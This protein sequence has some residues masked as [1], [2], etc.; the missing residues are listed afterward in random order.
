M[1]VHHLSARRS[2][3]SVE[4]MISFRGVAKSFGDVPALAKVDLDV[5][6]G[7]FIA[8]VGP[9]GCGK[10][11]LLGMAAGILQPTQG[12]V[13]FRG[14][15]V[16]GPNRRAGFITQQ[17]LLLPWRTVEENVRLPLE[18]R[19]ERKHAK[20]RVAEVLER[21]GLTTF[22]RKYPAQLSG[23]MRKRV[24]IA[25]TLVYNPD[26]YLMDEPFGSLDA[27]LRTVMHTEVLRLW[28]D[29][30]STIVFVTHDLTEAIVLAQRVAV[31]SRRPGVIQ[32]IEDIDMDKSGNRDAV[33]I[34]TDPGFQQSL[35]RLWSLLDKPE[36]H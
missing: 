2:I 12:E 6:G 27:Q 5:A 11:T 10:S 26:V 35:G 24:S 22:A 21:V 20:E 1:P 33:S 25:R 8:V 19:K 9:S 34:Q 23:G 7:E 36:I 14:E 3:V 28:R 15:R 4:P 13:R 17:D 32:S 31:I 29:L 30:G 16:V 18:F